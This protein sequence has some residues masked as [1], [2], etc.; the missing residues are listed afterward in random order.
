MTRN[1][2]ILITS[3]LLTTHVVAQKSYQ[4]KSPDGKL[5]ISV[6]VGNK[7]SYTVTHEND[8]V[9]TPS[10]VLMEVEGRE[11]FSVN[12]KLKNV[13]T[14]SVDNTIASPFYKRKEIRDHYN[15][16]ILNFREDFSLI[17]RAYNEGMAYRFVSTGKD[18]FIVKNEEATFNFDKDYKAYIPY[19]KTLI[20]ILYCRILIR[21]A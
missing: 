7:I 11:S 17:F 10:S 2:I 16:M 21:N 8:R 15:E 14:T 5:N 1:L 19:V 20:H 9:I 3:M 18:D 13:R 4:L 12:S 6:F